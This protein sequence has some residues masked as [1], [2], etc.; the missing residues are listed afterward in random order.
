M[1][2]DYEFYKNIYQGSHLDE[3]TFE[4][5]SRKA[6]AI[7]ARYT[8]DRVNEKTINNYPLTLQTKIKSCCCEL[9]EVNFY[10]DKINKLY[11]VND[12]G[13]SRVA[14]S[15]TAGAVSIS[16]DTATSKSY[17]DLNINEK[18]YKSVLDEY[19]YPQKIGNTYYNLMSGVI[20]NVQPNCYII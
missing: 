2:T 12:D 1:Y 13:T 20:S 17:L 11:I 19:L 7:I 18:R 4:K 5:F 9:A 6:E 14:K 8:L 10:I 15:K 16:Y 3:S